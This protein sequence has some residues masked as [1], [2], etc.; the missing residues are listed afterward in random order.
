ARSVPSE[1]G[2]EGVY[3]QGRRAAETARSN[4]AGRQNR[5]AR[6]G[7]GVERHLRNG[8]S[9]ILVWVSAR[10]KPASSAG[11]AL[12]RIADEKSELGARCCHTRLFLCDFSRTTG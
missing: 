1:T 8:F 4:G 7:R 10:A 3:P 6:G 2:A 12:H 9:R 5:P 11:C